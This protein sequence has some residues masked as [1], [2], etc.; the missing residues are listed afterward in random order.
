M[1]LAEKIHRAIYK[2]SGHI[3]ANVGSP[4]E[5]GFT[6]GKDSGSRDTTLDIKQA[7]LLFDEP[8]PG[9]DIWEAFQEWKRGYWAARLQR[10][11]AKAVSP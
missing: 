8:Q 3:N 4:F 2:K 10:I 5:A 6:I 9:D 7:W 1:D 11:R